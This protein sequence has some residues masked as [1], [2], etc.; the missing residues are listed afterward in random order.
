VSASMPDQEKRRRRELEE[1]TRRA[2]DTYRASLRDLEGREYEEAERRS[3][4]RLQRK[5]AEAEHQ[6][7]DSGGPTGQ[8][9]TPRRRWTDH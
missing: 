7:P 1:R 5:L 8:S 9:G 3:W 4:E 6:P 2:W